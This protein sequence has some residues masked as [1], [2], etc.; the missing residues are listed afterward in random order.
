MKRLKRAMVMREFFSQFAPIRRPVFQGVPGVPKGQA[1][2]GLRESREYTTGAGLVFQGGLGVPPQPDGG[3]PATTGTPAVVQGVPAFGVQEAAEKSALCRAGTPGT[4][5]TP[6]HDSPG[7]ERKGFSQAEDERAAVI[8]YDGCAPLVWAQAL[9]RLD[10]ARPPGDV[11]LGRWVRFIDDCG[12]FLD[13]GW[14]YRA[15]VLGW[16]PLHLFGCDRER[17][18][19]R[20]DRAGLIWLLDGHKIIAFTADTAVTETAT[21]VRQTYRRVAI[22][23]GQVV[24]AW[25]LE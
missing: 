12:R 10:P 1:P 3:S 5:S 17:P 11:P 25:E 4:P 15:E 8:E 19:A 22:E 14:A 21:G 23:P 9:A 20:I 2:C 6:K 7:A 24:L 18:W 16:G 13:D